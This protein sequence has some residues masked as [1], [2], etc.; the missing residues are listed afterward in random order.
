M[1]A[2]L[3]EDKLKIAGLLLPLAARLFNDGAEAAVDRLFLLALGLIIAYAFGA[4]FARTAER[5]IGSG[6]VPFI[7]AFVVFLPTPVSPA[8]AAISISFGSIFGREV[9]GGKPVLPPALIALAFALFSYPDGG[10]QLQQMSDLAIDPIFTVA[11]LAGGAIFLW[12][13]FLAWRIATGAFLGSVLVS[14]L[15]HGSIS[16]EQPLLGTYIA[17][18]LF[19]AASAENTPRSKSACW[20]LGF[21]V[22]VLVMILRSADPD[23]PDG[24]VFAVLLG[25]LFAPLIDRFFVWRSQHG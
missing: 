12:R 18:V 14:P 20:L 10:F 17:G 24:V 2:L 22:G 15:T 21:L 1:L 16:W 8:S 23:Q 13:D 25:C 19:L 11:S 5:P 6:I 3:N 4:G 9:F 7:L